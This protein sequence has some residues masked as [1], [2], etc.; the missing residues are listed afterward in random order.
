MS[1]SWTPLYNYNV[2][3]F[4]TPYILQPPWHKRN[5]TTVILSSVTVC[6]SR[7][8]RKV[9]LT[10]IFKMKRFRFKIYVW[11]ESETASRT[12]CHPYMFCPVKKSWL[13]DH[14]SRWLILHLFNKISCGDVVATLRRPTVT[15]A[16]FRQGLTLPCIHWKLV[17][18]RNTRM[19]MLAL[20]C[21]PT[22]YCQL[23]PSDSFLI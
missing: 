17:M 20:W 22:D 18:R 23:V 14:F 2:I 7:M 11:R 10:N 21:L 4:Q 8:T 16:G 1:L 9:N 12:L 3:L 5:P 19:T 15:V 13:S 6:T